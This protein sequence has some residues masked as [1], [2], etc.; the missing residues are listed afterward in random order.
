MGTGGAAKMTDEHKTPKWLFRGLNQLFKFDIDLFATRE[1]AL[2][3]NYYSL[4]DSA[5]DKDWSQWKSCFAHPPYSRPNIAKTVEKAYSY[6]GSTKTTIVLLLPYD[7]TDWGR[8]FVFGRSDWVLLPHKRLYTS[9]RKCSMLVVYNYQ[10][11]PQ[12]I[13][14]FLDTTKWEEKWEEEMSWKWEE[15][16]S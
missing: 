7:T 15:D 13:I 8:R 12:Q 6:Q 9:N 11:Q 5:Y 1:N 2:C 10:P 3:D 14:Q 16:M 4:Q